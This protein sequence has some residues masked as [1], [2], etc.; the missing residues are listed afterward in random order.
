MVPAPSTPCSCR[1]TEALSSSTSSKV[2]RRATIA[3]AKTTPPT[4]LTPGFEH[5]PDWSNDERCAFPSTP[6]PSLPPCQPLHFAH[7]HDGYAIADSDTLQAEIGRLRW[8]DPDQEVYE[9][10]LSALENISTIRTSARRAPI[11]PDS[12]GTRLKK[13]EASIATLDATQGRAVVETVDGVQ[14]IRG[15]AGSG[16]TIVLALKAAYLHV[17]HPEWRIAVTFHTRSLKG[18]YRRLIS[19]FHVEQT[20]EEP[21]WTHMRIINSWG[22][23]FGNAGDDG[24]YLEFC[25]THDI[26]YLDFR[27]AKQR[28]GAGNRAFAGACRRAID[29]FR[30]SGSKKPI[31]DAILVDEA[32]DL[33]DAFLQICYELLRDPCRLAYAYDELQNLSGAAVSTPDAMFGKDANDVPRVQLYAPGSDIILQKC[34]R[35]SRPVLVTAH[36]LGF[37]IYRQPVD[38]ETSG[39]IQMFDNPPLWQEIGY[40]IQ[41]GELQVGAEVTLSRTSDTSPEFLEEHSDIQDLVKFVHFDNKADQNAWVANEIQKNLRDDELRC[42]DI[43]VINPDPLTT[44]DEVGPIRAHLLDLG[45]NSHVAGVDTSAD[46]FHREDVDSVTFTGIYRAKGSEA[47]M[48]YV[49]NAQDCHGTG[50]NLATIRN[51]LFVAITRSKAWVRVL[52]T[53]AGM[54][55]IEQEYQRVRDHH[56][57]LRFTYPTDKQRQHLRVIHRDMTATESQRLLQHTQD[58]RKLIVDLQEERVRKE[59]L[60]AETLVTLKTLLD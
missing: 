31:Y 54:K 55:A 51:R 8:E 50:H 10:A 3:H 21:D 38:T 22:S 12:R 32:Q 53:G 24:L 56:F 47:G 39:L 58:L 36:A 35:N 18:H 27:A 52:G 60:D 41:E 4:C 13:L 19:R 20:G 23:P 42:D 2:T 57:R 59:D 9:A 6:S 11:R 1:P 44:R 37:G 33:P 15:L 30:Q 14:R 29:H 43:V 17:Q 28:F 7:A 45:I 34:Y 48:V 26:E 40:H 49:I 25:S 16:K 46:E 5:T